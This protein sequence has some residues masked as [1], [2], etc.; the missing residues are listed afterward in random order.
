MHALMFRVISLGS[1]DRHRSRFVLRPRRPQRAS[2][3]EY[4]DIMTN[5]SIMPASL[6]ILV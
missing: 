1:D 6:V 2:N 5:Y 4:I 3:R